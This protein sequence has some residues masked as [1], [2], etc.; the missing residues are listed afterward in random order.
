[1]RLRNSLLLLS[2]AA[3][4]C[5]G[6]MFA[7]ARGNT[8]S[9]GVIHGTIYDP[10]GEVVTRAR[11]DLLQSMVAIAQTETDERGRYRFSGLS[12]GAYEVAANAPGLTSTSAPFEL[13]PGNETTLDLH[14]SLS[15][16]QEQVV[17]SSSLGG[18]LE[19]Q[20]GSSVSVINKQQIQNEGAETLADALRNVP[21]VDINRTGQLGAVTSAFVRGG[22]SNYN[23]VMIDG[24]PMNDFG[25]GFDLAP[26]P[27]NGIERVEITRGPESALYGENAIGSVINVV[28]ET[29]E[30]SPHF[31]FTGEGGSY[32]TY[33]LATG[34]A[35]LNHGI[36]WAY[37]L[38]RLSTQ[39]PVMD[40]SYRNQTSFV[41]LGYSQNPRRQFVLH[42]FGDAGR[43]E[44]PGPW[45]S[46]P[47]GL[48]PGIANSALP[49]KQDL[50]GYQAGYTE[51]FSSRF[52]QVSTVSVATDQY[53]FP[54]TSSF[55]ESSF[56][57]SERLVA[58][59]RSE[60]TL[61]AKDVLLAGFEYDREQFRDTYVSDSDGV[62]FT[63]PRQSFAAFVENR[64][65]A[66]DRWFLSTGVRVDSIFTGSLA[67]DETDAG[68]PFIPASSVEQVN[69]RISVAYLVKESSGGW[70]GLTRLHSSFGTG[71]RPPDGLELAFTNNPDLKPER[72]ISGDAGVEQRFFGDKMAMD[73]TYFYNYFT[74]QI[75]T[76]GGSFQN[77]S[78][79][80]SANLQ[81]SR[82]YGVESS[83][84][85]HPLRSIELSAEY[86]WL[87]TA[88]L[89][90]NGSSNQ[91]PVPF[92]VGDPLI[93][94]PRNSAGY[95]ATW[96]HGRLMLNSNASIRGAVLDLEPNYGSYACELGLPCLFWSG[97]YVDA[98]AG[99]S[100]RLPRGVEI[101]GH[102]N[103]FLNEHYEESFGYPALRLNFISGIRF[104]F[105]RG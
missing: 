22:N 94:R 87:N 16:V 41:T 38:S 91:A 24:I 56:W 83:L 54:A 11:V 37:D 102:V 4:L 47:D 85:V 36:D 51:Q 35:G 67:A 23:L 27:T 29:G 1:M 52:R 76:L 88:V 2:A 64:W 14:L 15:A 19:P 62:P 81:N 66:G 42:F 44:N 59:T 7:Q 46:D 58:N 6:S 5:C 84:R 93:R 43:D 53:S 12:A 8:P 49:Q 39:E 78:T 101:F 105:S 92:V 18:A 68:R 17:V 20:I 48:Y 26:L 97:S 33:N 71:I 45:G 9:G 95:D 86:T 61:S 99:F 104:T 96:T 98:N 63:L 73:V 74:D 75:V 103:N 25:G 28:S 89:A 50:F 77:L 57:K 79:F 10:G 69:P 13:R 40:D 60:I 65:S 32:D 72:S 31:S 100:Y 70:L 90:L 30:A 82:A 21:G 80:T 55:S 34:G 3:M